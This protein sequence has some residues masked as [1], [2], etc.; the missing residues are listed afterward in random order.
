MRHKH[1]LLKLSNPGEGGLGKLRCDHA[2]IAMD[3]EAVGPIVAIFGLRQL[4]PSWSSKEMKT[5]RIDM[6]RSGRSEAVFKV[7]NGIWGATME[8]Q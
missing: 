7:L 8:L 6:W 3:A 5:G 2:Q 4:R 1:R